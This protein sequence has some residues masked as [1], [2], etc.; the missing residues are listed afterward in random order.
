M[1]KTSSTPACS[2]DRTRLCAPV[3]V[4]RPRERAPATS[5]GLAGR[6]VPL[7]A[8]PAALTSS[9]VLLG[10]AGVV[11]VVVLVVLVVL[12]VRKSLPDNEKTPRPVVGTARGCARS[13]AGGPARQR[14]VRVRARNARPQPLPHLPLRQPAPSFVSHLGTPV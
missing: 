13:G 14:A 10:A 7:P 8:S 3:I 4:V 9:P 2:R 12:V 11:L 6:S 5:A 1:P